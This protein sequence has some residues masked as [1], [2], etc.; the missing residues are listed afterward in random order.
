MRRSFGACSHLAAILAGWLLVADAA[1]PPEWKRVLYEQPFSQAESL[2]DIRVTDPR[3]WRWSEADGGALELHQQSK[4]QAPVRSPFNIALLSKH[5][6]RDFT[7]ELECQQTSGE[8][9]HRDLCF[10]F[11]LQSPTR[12]YYAHLASAAD[13]HA[14]NIFVVNEA[15]RL[16]TARET[17][18]GVQWGS[19]QAW[20]KIRIERKVVEGT[21]RVFFNDLS[22]PIMTSVDKTF[23]EGFIGVGSFDDVGRFRN[24]RI[25]GTAV[26]GA[27]AAFYTAL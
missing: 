27:G 23:V 3:A 6:F 4:Y 19:P 13:D 5:R 7:L 26:D 12:F 15:P 24:V 8:Y 14:H 9:G 10:F 20:H 22:R 1:A 25:Q 18:P 16:R 2:R 21:V 11:G 17:T